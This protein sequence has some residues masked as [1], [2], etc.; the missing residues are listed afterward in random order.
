MR[1][2]A[3]QAQGETE[4]EGEVGAETAGQASSTTRGYWL[5]KAEPDSR[6]VKGKDVKVSR[7]SV[8]PS[9]APA[10]AL[11]STRRARADFAHGIALCCIARA[12]LVWG[13]AAT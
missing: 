1:K 4:G 13:R 12:V 9:S 10:A 11:T 8:P 2:P 5:M 7:P 3:E 6:I